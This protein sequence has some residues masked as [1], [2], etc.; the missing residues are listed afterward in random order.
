VGSRSASTPEGHAR[1]TREAQEARDIGDHDTEVRLLAS[2]LRGETLRATRA[3]GAASARGDQRR[4]SPQRD[5]AGLEVVVA[6]ALRSAQ[7]GT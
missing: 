7:V 2:V 1:L 6:L 5:E 3:E 4:D